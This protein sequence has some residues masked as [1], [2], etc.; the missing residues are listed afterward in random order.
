VS[1]AVCHFRFAVR[2]A[3]LASSLALAAACGTGSSNG[4]PGAG[5][6]GGG[7]RGGGGAGGSAAAAGGAGGA[8]T[9]NGCLDLVGGTNT[10]PTP[11][12]HPDGICD[13]YGS[14]TLNVAAAGATPLL[15]NA[16]LYRVDATGQNLGASGG[17]V[18][19]GAWSTVPSVQNIPGNYGGQLF[20]ARVPLPSSADFFS[21]S[22]TISIALAPGDN[23]FYFF[24][25]G[26]DPR[27][28]T[29]GF[30][31]NLWLGSSTPDAP[32]LSGFA[33]KPSGTLMADGATGCSPAYDDTCAASAGTLTAATP[34]AVTLTDFTINRVGGDA[35]R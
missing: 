8:A 3:V 30:G 27:G 17:H 28:G 7:G 24:G 18:T 20:I 16:T 9:G 23:V 15:T 14:F 6:H 11:V 19:L 29:Y 35:A 12:S 22:A 25:N 34:P 21:P 33:A 13:T 31:L 1:Q 32:A 5:G 4:K 10:T 2:T 26:D